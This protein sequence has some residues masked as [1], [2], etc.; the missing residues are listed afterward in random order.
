ML[1]NQRTGTK[2]T[3]LEILLS[4]LTQLVALFVTVELSSFIG[5]GQDLNVFRKYAAINLYL[6]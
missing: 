2:Y 1:R 3:L 4:L 5:A 6:A